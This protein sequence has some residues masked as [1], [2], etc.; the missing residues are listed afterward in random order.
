MQNVLTAKANVAR[1][2][3]QDSRERGRKQDQ[4]QI[5]Q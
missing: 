5:F 2:L 3:G 1:L 4:R